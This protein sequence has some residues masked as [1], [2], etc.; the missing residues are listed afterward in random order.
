VAQPPV[1]L[2]QQIRVMVV[3]PKTE[4]TAALVAAALVALVLAQLELQ[5]QVLAAQV[6]HLLLQDLP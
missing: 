4:T 5:L 3:V 6:L 1:D 2:V